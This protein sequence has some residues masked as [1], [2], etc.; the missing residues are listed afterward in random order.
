MSCDDK[1]ICGREEEVMKCQKDLCFVLNQY[2]GKIGYAAIVSVL[3]NNVL[4][5]KQ[6]LLD[7]VSGAY[8]FY[9]KEKS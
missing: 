8:D 9:T 2:E 4:V 5:E 1:C 6:A 7:D 3:I